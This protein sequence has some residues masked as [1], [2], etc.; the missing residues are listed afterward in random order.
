MRLCLKKTKKE[1]E[2]RKK[3]RNEKEGRGG[4]RKF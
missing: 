1:R 4:E 3:E 2:G